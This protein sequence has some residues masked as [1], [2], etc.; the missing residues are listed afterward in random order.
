MT[1][2]ESRHQRRSARV[3]A[4]SGT[5]LSTTAHGGYDEVMNRSAT[6]ALA[7]SVLSGCF[8]D[9][10]PYDGGGEYPT[11]ECT[12]A[13]RAVIAETA[14]E[15][16]WD[17]DVTDTDGR[18]RG[19]T[20]DF[21]LYD[22]HGYRVR[23]THFCGDTVLL[24][25]GDMRTRDDPEAETPLG[26]L[27][28]LQ[29]WL[30]ARDPEAPPLTIMTT[31]YADEDGDTPTVGDLRRF[32]EQ[33][34]AERGVDAWT[35]TYPTPGGEE[36]RTILTLQDPWRFPDAAVATYVM[37]LASDVPVGDGPDRRFRR[38]HEVRDRWTFRAAPN[39]VVLQPSLRILAIGEDPVEDGIVEELQTAPELGR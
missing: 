35:Y 8:G 17:T 30:D 7:L 23:L 29:G 25:V 31:W 2:P 18:Q 26:W 27:D 19:R 36:T 32:R 9:V 37:A 4:R 3:S 21:R 33:V 14:G 10:G 11:T 20:R 22:E 24:V 1:P 28:E 12:Q 13:F 5:R 39:F 16:L 6:A 38:E 15:E 34:E